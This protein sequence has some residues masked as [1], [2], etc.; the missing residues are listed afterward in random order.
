MRLWIRQEAFKGLERAPLLIVDDAPLNIKLFSQIVECDYDILI[1]TNRQDP[2]KIAGREKPDLILLDVMMPGMD[3]YE[4]C[5]RL[6]DDPVTREIPVIFI[7]AMDQEDDETRGLAL[8][9][10]EY[11]ITK[12]VRPSPWS[13]AWSA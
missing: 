1:A 12:P 5:A 4:T 6:K 13:T 8:G 9:A 11:Y 7:T 10:I 3:G 2:L